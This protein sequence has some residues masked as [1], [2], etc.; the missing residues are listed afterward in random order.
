MVEHVSVFQ[1]ALPAELVEVRIGDVM[2][3]ASRAHPRSHGCAA[4]HLR[5]GTLAALPQGTC[6]L[7]GAERQNLAVI[8][9]SSGH[10]HYAI[11]LRAGTLITTVAA[12]LRTFS[13]KAGWP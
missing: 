2:K 5:A 7:S 13:A 11:H 10:A 1:L 6:A 3:L 8:T 9:S 4:L 12:A